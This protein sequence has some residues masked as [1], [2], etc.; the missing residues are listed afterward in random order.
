MLV[1]YL[2]TF[3]AKLVSVQSLPLIFPIPIPKSPSFYFSAA[4]NTIANYKCRMESIAV[5]KPQIGNPP[6]TQDHINIFMLQWRVYS[7]FILS[8]YFLFTSY[9]CLQTFQRAD[10]SQSR[11]LS[12]QDISIWMYNHSWLFLEHLNTTL[13]RCKIPTDIFL[14]FFG[15]FSFL[16]NDVRKEI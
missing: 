6:G 14:C 9:F 11:R 10:S 13:Q 7:T 16:K 8:S 5:A 15:Q 2:L 3:P 4:Y 12:R 1:I